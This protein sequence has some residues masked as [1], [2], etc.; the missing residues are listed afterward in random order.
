MTPGLQLYLDFCVFVLGAVI[1][2]FLNVC[3]HRMPR[4]QSIVTPPSH[5]PHCNELIR[6]YDN[7][8][9]VSYLVLR[10]RCRH[11]GARFTARYFMVELLTATLFLAVLLRFGWHWVVPVYWL[12]VAGLIAATFIDF[13]H[14]IIPDEIT[15]GGV[16]VG[17]IISLAL[18]SLHHTASHWKSA[19]QSLLGIVTG[20]LCLLIIV[21][22][23]KLALGRFKITLPAGTLIEIGDGKLRYLDQELLWQDMFTR[24]SDRIR[25]KAVT[26]KFLDQSLENVDVRV[27][28]THLEVLDQQYDLAQIGRIEATTDMLI[29]PREAMGM[30][31]VKLL[32]GIGAFVGW[33][34]TLFTIFVSSVVGGIIGM[35]LVLLNKKDL[36]SRI[37]YG[38]YIAFGALVW[39]FCG[40]EV[41]DAYINFMDWAVNHLLNSARG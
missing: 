26:L 10:G 30:G 40:R 29:I 19:L 3:V 28:D 6:W 22:L 37:P 38:P 41:I 15:I 36:Q 9:L 31:D 24:A 21:E 8:P 18:P 34:A 39:I 2:S 16:V 20:G 12:F 11:C 4:A 35:V 27:S 13:E 7:I 33:P 14:Y 17:L 23:G 1:G 32:A 25:F 5:C